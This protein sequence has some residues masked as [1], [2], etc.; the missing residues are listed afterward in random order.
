MKTKRLN[1]CRAQLT[2]FEIK[3]KTPNRK[4]HV[5]FQ[6]ERALQPK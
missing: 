3:M 2:T 6:D 1:Y 4:L 5:T